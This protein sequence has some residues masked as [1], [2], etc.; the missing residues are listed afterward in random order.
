MINT[1]LELP[2]ATVTVWTALALGLA[3]AAADNKHDLFFCVN[4]SGQGQ[5]MGSAVSVASG[6]Y[7]SNDRQNFEHVGFNHFRTFAATHDPQDPGTLFVS[8]LDGVLRGRDKGRSWRRMTGWD[9]TEPKAILFDPN[10]PTHIYAGLP[11]GIAVSHDRGETWR[12]MNEGIRRSYT[13]SLAIDRTK[14]GR[15]LAGTEL[16][17]YLTEDGARTWKLV[18]ATRKV[19]YDLRQSPHDPRTFLAVTSA[20][21]ALRS[22]DGGRTWQKIAGVPSQHTLHYGHF[23]PHHA[24]RLVICGWDAGVLV[25]ED[26]GRTWHDR[27]AGL[28]NQQVWCVN[29]DPDLPNRLYAAPYLKP[30]F[31]SDD[32]GQTWRPLCFEKA[33]VYNFMFVPRP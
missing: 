19:T 21:G 24:R 14:A 20:D 2:R 28:P 16:G 12:R 4:L 32:F 13:H 11:D 10:A 22:N 29:P 6:L 23:D 31:A 15:V 26:D 3:C 33:I 1:G 18:Q 27:S 5:V 9:M 25:S 17:I 7:R 30:V 8:V